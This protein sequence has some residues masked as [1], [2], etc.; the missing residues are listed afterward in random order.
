MELY[1]AG[2]TPIDLTGLR[3]ID[4]NRHL[5][6]TDVNSFD[7]FVPAFDVYGNPSTLPPGGHA[8]MWASVHL[9]GVNVDAPLADLQFH[10]GIP[11]HWPIQENDEV[12]VLDSASRVVDFV[13]W[14]SGGELGTPPTFGWDPTYQAVIGMP[15]N[16]QSI[17]LTP[18][19]LDSDSSACWEDTGSGQAGLRLECAGQP[20]TIDSDPVAGRITSLGGPNN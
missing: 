18:G 11:F 19:G 7:L 10:T 14:G 3:L 20:T 2:P 9:S 4:S 1:N 16:G 6:E 15:L 12:W 13:A 17:S 5:G 8:V